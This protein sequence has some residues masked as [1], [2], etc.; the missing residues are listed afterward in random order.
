MPEDR[1]PQIGWTSR[2]VNNLGRIRGTARVQSKHGRARH[3]MDQ[4]SRII[5]I[6][7]DSRNRIATNLC[8]C[9]AALR[10][11]AGDPGERGLR[12]G[13]LVHPKR[14]AYRIT[15]PP[16]TWNAQSRNEGN[17][18]EAMSRITSTDIS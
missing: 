18:Q 7:R 14:S 10:S 8:H 15:I 9:N 4:M 1:D 3:F 6:H 16:V 2:P 5:R 12:R 11:S 13:V 17:T